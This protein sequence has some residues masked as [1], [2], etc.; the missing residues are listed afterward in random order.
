MSIE[1]KLNLVLENYQIVDDQ[2]ENSIQQ[3]LCNLE[4][5]RTEYEKSLEQLLNSLVNKE[6]PQD[7]DF[8]LTINS[9]NEPNEIINQNNVPLDAEN[10]SMPDKMYSII[11]SALD[12]EDNNGITR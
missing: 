7:P 10:S 9:I 12:A 8:N 11:V 2:V 6:I 3:H 4:R 1:N 5:L